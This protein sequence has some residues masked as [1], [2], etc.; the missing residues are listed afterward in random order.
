MVCIG[1]FPVKILDDTR[2]GLADMNIL[3]KLRPAQDAQWDQI[4]V[5]SCLRGTR[6]ME[7][8]GIRR[9]IDCETER[10]IYM[11]GGLVG[12]GKTA[13][14]RSVSELACSHGILGASY[15]CSR[16]SNKRSDIQ[17]I[18]PTIAFQLAFFCRRFRADVIMAIRK[19]PSIVRT[20]PDKQLEGLIVKP[21]QRIFESTLASA[22]NELGFC[23]SLPDREFGPLIEKPLRDLILSLENSL[24]KLEGDSLPL[25]SIVEP[26]N[27]IITSIAHRPKVDHWLTDEQFM[28]LVVEPIRKIIMSIHRLTCDRPVSDERFQESILNSIRIKIMSLKDTLGLGY[29]LSDTQLKQL[30]LEPLQDLVISIEDRLSDSEVHG[31]KKVKKK[32]VESIVQCMK[33]IITSRKGNLDF[34]LDGQIR[35]LISQNIGPFSGPVVVVIDALDECKD[36]AA[37]ETLLLALASHIPSIPFLKVFATSRPELSNRLALEDPAVKLL[38]KVSS[39]HQVDRGRVDQDIRLLLDT[40]LAKIADKRRRDKVKL[41]E[42]WP[43]RDLMEKLV[44][45]SSGLFIVAITICKYLESPGD[46]VQRLEL[47]AND[48]TTFSEGLLAIDKLY[49]HIIKAAFRRFLD[50]KLI[51]RCHSVVGTIVL[52]FDPLPLREL[53]QMLGVTSS[54]IRELLSDLHSVLVIPSNDEGIIHTFHAS[55]HDFLTDMGR[56]GRLVH[57]QPTRQHQEITRHLLQ[58]MI[59]GLKRNICRLDVLRLNSEVADLA[60]RRGKYIGGLLAYAC[61]YLAEH[62]QH[63][64]PTERNAQN[65]VQEL[66]QLIQTKL[67][68]WIEVLSLLGDVNLAEK[69]FRM[70]KEWCS[71]CF[72]ESSPLDKYLRIVI[73]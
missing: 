71:V 51:S 49:Q 16:E 29:S 31:E 45:K 61:R 36:S 10:R 18:F 52:L 60:G 67:L 27:G 43:P 38:S 5:E 11:L 2:F 62:L 22:K 63:V 30:V 21:I 53:A 12:T 4:R 24:A 9:W 17:S 1:R 6:V 65:L 72:G 46:L 15:F 37:S 42:H 39:L 19:S 33:K 41:P 66:D 35:D 40:R 3:D 28:E 68:Y 32:E 25:S 54:H 55:F 50:K 64:A 44:E 57:V 73:P 13:I 58:C 26:I 69:S 23:Q 59:Q 56:C 47:I 7:L 34:A 20:T 14:A 8:G 70:V 48:R